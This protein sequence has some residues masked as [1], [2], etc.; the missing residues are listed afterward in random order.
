VSGDLLTS[1]VAL[2]RIDTEENPR[3]SRYTNERSSNG[4]LTKNEDQQTGRYPIFTYI[5]RND[6]GLRANSFVDG[7]SIEVITWA[8][9]DVRFDG[10]EWFHL[11]G[12][13]CLK[14]NPHWPIGARASKST[15]KAPCASVAGR[16]D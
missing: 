14:N 1:L 8:D 13:R 4:R 7:Y 12:P 3:V 6:S 11:I 2:F 5:R 15:A 16:P 9:F 10:V